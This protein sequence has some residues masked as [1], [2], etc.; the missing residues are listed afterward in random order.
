MP[1]LESTFPS[2]AARG[3][4]DWL[5]FRGGEAL[6]GETR[7]NLIR[8]AAILIFYGHHLVNV[9]VFRDDPTLL[10]RYHTSATAVVLA[11]SLTVLVIH[12]CLSLPRVPNGW[13]SPRLG[14]TR[15]SLR[16]CSACRAISK[17]LW[18]CCTSWS[19]SR[20]GFVFRCR[21]SIWQRLRAWPPT[22]DTWAWPFLV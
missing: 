14:P 21:W 6:A 5:Q 20:R 8:L 15:F 9:F 16:S 10:G 17:V 18:L 12:L 11:W 13:E 2:L 3:S 4:V 19:S 22:L 1:N 7:V